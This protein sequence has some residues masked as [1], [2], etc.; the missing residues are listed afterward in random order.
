MVHD[1][2]VSNAFARFWAS[3]GRIFNL[4]TRKSPSW[5]PFVS[6]TMLYLAGS[7]LRQTQWTVLSAVGR[8]APGLPERQLSQDELPPERQLAIVPALTL[9]TVRP[10]RGT[11][12]RN[13]PCAC[14]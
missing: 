6:Q 10:P 2:L 9:L 1:N 7:G 14:Q 11:G 4:N 3:I 5:R 13:R 12:A 8:I